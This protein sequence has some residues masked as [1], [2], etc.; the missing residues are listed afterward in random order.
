MKVVKAFFRSV[1]AFLR[2]LFQAIGHVRSGGRTTQTR[3]RKRAARPRI[4]HECHQ[5]IA[6]SDDWRDHLNH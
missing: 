3:A 4:C 5:P 2:R 1:G 6:Q